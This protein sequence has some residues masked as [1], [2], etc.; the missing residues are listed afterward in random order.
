MKA[1]MRDVARLANVSVATVSMVINH[2]DERISKKTREKVFDAI[3]ELNYEPNRFAQ[4]LKTGTSHLMALLVPDLR[5]DFYAQIAQEGMIEAS[6]HG[7]FLTF[8]GLPTT[9]EERDRLKRVIG[10]GEFAGILMVSRQFNEILLED[11]AKREVPCII[12]DE[13][14]DKGRNFSLVAGDNVAGGQLAAEYLYAMGHEKLAC[15]TG[16][17][18]TP[19]SKSRLKGFLEQLNSYG[20]TVAREH[21]L[22]GD[23]TLEGG[24]RCGKK[25]MDQDITGIFTFNDLSAIGCMK[26][27]YD[28]GKRVPE[29]LSIIGYDNITMS[30][31]THPKLASIDQDPK[32][33]ATLAVEAL[34]KGIEGKEIDKVSLI[35]PTLK[36]GETVLDLKKG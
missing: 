14:I 20:I 15:I 12:L 8:I 32:R 31:Y 21:I 4:M 6:K 34:I 26:A 2:K 33:I 36:R 16:P 27:A 29:D 30:N 13:S 23:Y 7:Y 18:N 25:L 3:K 35:E 11:I 10:N 19:N 24:Y 9:D 17:K 5:N 22:V 28:C 1:T